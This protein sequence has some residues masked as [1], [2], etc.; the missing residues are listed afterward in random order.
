VFSEESF[1]VT[2]QGQKQ[3][4]KTLILFKAFTGKFQCH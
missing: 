4:F 3:S 1:N 2:G